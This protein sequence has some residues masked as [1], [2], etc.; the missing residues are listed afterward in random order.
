MD[1][2]GVL[3]LCSVAAEERMHNT[4]PVGQNN[5]CGEREVKSQGLN[6]QHKEG[7]LSAGLILDIGI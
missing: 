4:C 1:L 6:P 5:V 2:S 7:L 3:R